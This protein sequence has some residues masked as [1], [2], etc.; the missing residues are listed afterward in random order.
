[1]SR[2]RS[3]SPDLQAEWRSSKTCIR[4]GFTLIE[5]LT[6]IAIIAILAAFLLPALSKAKQRATTGA[7]LNNVKQLALAWIMYADDCSDRLAN[8]NTYTSVMPLD[9]APE[10]VPWRTQIDQMSVPLPADIMANTEAAQK[11]L[12]EMGFNMRA[13]GVEG[14]LWKYNPN[15][16]SVHCPGDNRYQ[17]RFGLANNALYSGRYGWDSYSGVGFLN[18]E[19][20]ADDNNLHKQT[21]ISRPSDKLIWVEGAD[22]RGENLGSWEMVNYGTAS[23]GFSDA[24]FQDSPAAFHVNSAVF[25]FCDGHA[26]NHRWLDPTTIAFA[27]DLY[28]YKDGGPRGSGI[29]GGD[30][31]SSAAEHAGNVDAVWC[32]KHY[33][34]KQNP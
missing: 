32:G 27:N 28:V 30:A 25:N 3:Y 33:P 13:P 10:G 4:Y 24:E 21:E 20:R 18:G 16:D 9:K 7:C 14:P 23:L 15:A 11:Y 5:L 29:T 2:S 8:L 22:M 19:N 31:Y 6:V 1:M 34:G 12:S 17:L 26:E